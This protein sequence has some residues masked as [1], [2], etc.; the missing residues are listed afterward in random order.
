M[1]TPA[2]R[3]DG[4]GR[5][6]GNACTRLGKPGQHDL[7]LGDEQAAAEMAGHAEARRNEDRFEL[8]SLFS[9]SSGYGVGDR[10]DA[11][12]AGADDALATTS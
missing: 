7:D 9:N 4:R 3:G 12:L 11:G 1:G 2:E 10:R 5:Q 6:V 8:S